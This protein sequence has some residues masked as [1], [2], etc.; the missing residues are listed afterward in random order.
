MRYGLIG[1]KLGHSYSREIH[2]LAG[3]YDYELREIAPEELGAFLEKR[4]FLGI[5]VTIPYKQAVMPYLDETD[6][7]AREIGAVNTIVNRGGKLMGFNT[8]FT[9]LKNLILHNGIVLSGRKVL[10]LGSGGTSKTATAVARALGAGSVV[11]AGRTAKPGVVSYEEA[12]AV[13]SDASVI[14]NTTPCGMYPDVLSTPVSLEPFRC[15][16][17]L[18]DV[19]YNPLR[20]RLV[21]EA[22]RRGIRSCNGLYMLASQGVAASALFLDAPM[23][24]EKALSVYRQLYRQK[25]NIVLTG[26]PGSGK[27]TTGKILAERLGMAFADTDDLIM[28]QT[29]RHPAQIIREDGEEAFREIE[30]G[31]VREIS[32]ASDT[33][34]STG[35]GVVLKDEN[36]TCLKGNGIVFFIDRDIRDIVPYSDRPLSDTR[37]KLEETYRRRYPLYCSTCDFRIKA[38]SSC[39][40]TAH[41]ITEAPDEA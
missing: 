11:I 17:A 34:V 32:A 21:M 9:G 33:V 40:E 41:L 23:K 10:I 26:M 28:R 24:E 31:I 39:E 29:G 1:G 27:S 3:G 8:D 35:G 37:E 18:V 22:Q 19:I 6:A 25:R 12:Y 5:N 4:D 36:M 16:E 38:G 15:L 13:H 20:T 14:I 2:A 30:S 7:L